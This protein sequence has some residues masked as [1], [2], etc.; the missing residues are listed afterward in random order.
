MP[1]IAFTLIN[2]HDSPYCMNHYSRQDLLKVYMKYW[3]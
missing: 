1:K 3:S 2:A